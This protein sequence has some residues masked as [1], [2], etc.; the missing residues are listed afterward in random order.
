MLIGKIE[1][2]VSEYNFFYGEIGNPSF[3][4]EIYQ[5]KAS[6]FESLIKKFSDFCNVDFCNV[7][8]F[9]GAFEVCKHENAAGEEPTER[10]N[11][12]FESG[13]INL[14]IANYT[15]YLYEEKEADKKEAAEVLEI[16]KGWKK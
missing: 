11:A 13:K 12:K 7:D 6:C 16:M 4:G 8:F 15:C 2:F 14:F 3:F 9:N 10:E 5:I 1:K